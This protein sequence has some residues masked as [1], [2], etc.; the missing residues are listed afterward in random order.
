MYNVSKTPIL[1][2]GTN[3]LQPQ[4][5]ERTPSLPDPARFEPSQASVAVIPSLTNPQSAPVSSRRPPTPTEDIEQEL[6][7]LRRRVSALEEYIAAS[8]AGGS[9]IDATK[10]TSQATQPRQ[11]G[12]NHES[13]TANSGLQE[14]QSSQHYGRH[15]DV[16][17]ELPSSQQL[18]L[19]KSRLYG[20]SHWTHGG[21]EVSKYLNF[22]FRLPLLIVSVQKSCCVEYRH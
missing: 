4:S 6:E 3:A 1:G 19:N 12:Q 15:S 2:T 11:I 13:I 14:R 7:V 21:N 22:W 16:A 20:P 10:E 8:T 9:I 18:M 5:L 17:Q